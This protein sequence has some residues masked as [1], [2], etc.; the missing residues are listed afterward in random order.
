MPDESTH[1]PS[2]GAA[3]DLAAKLQSQTGAADSADAAD[4]MRH[5]AETAAQIAQEIETAGSP[6]SVTPAESA[7]AVAAPVESPT[8]ADAGALAADVPASPTAPAAA[9][10]A[11]ATA[12]DTAT[13]GTSDPSAGFAP[14]ISRL[15]AIEVPIIVQLGMRRLS[16]GE[17]M[18][19]AVGAIIEFQKPAD[20][21]LELLANNR[22]VGKGQAVKVGENFGLRL[23]AS[24]SVRETIRALG[25]K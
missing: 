3:D 1:V 8:L 18:R 15:L 12:Q 9:V 7:G 23:T 10:R 11:P 2:P 25:I 16:V 20:E 5:A 4:A 14:E 6:A 21:D 13:V 22:P 17:V 24:G 19:F